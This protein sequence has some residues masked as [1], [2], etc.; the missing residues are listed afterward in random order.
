MDSRSLAVA[1]ALMVLVAGCSIGSHGPARP[2]AVAASRPTPPLSAVVELPSRTMRAG[3]A[4]SA[5]VI[6]DNHTGHAIAVSGCDR[7]FQV[8]L[9]SADYHPAVAWAS[10]LRHFTIR[11]GQSSYPATITASYTDCYQGQP[12][13]DLRPCLPGGAMPPLPAGDYQALLFQASYAVPAP[14]PIPVRVTAAAKKS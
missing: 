7:L 12:Q 10:C 4:M 8:A 3:S 1:F 11:I 2:G 13:G 6:V 9:V 14:P 5:R